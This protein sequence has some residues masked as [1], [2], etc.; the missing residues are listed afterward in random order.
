MI[1]PWVRDDGRGNMLLSSSRRLDPM[2]AAGWG[3]D[4][5]HPM[6]DEL[7]EEVHHGPAIP[8]TFEP[9]DPTKRPCTL[10]GAPG[11]VS[12]AQIASAS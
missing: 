6:P 10:A 9:F 2:T 11:G 3:K 8:Q 12:A 4:G 7:A 5:A 1:S